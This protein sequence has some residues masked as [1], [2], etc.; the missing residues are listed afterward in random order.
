MAPICEVLFGPAPRASGDWGGQV[1]PLCLL[2]DALIRVSGSPGQVDRLSLPQLL[3]RL[4]AAE[5]L[6]FPML[7]PHQQPAWHAFLVQLAY[8]ALESTELAKPPTDAASWSSLLRALTPDHPADEPWCLVVDDWQR[9]AFLQSPCLAGGQADYRRVLGSA[10][11]IDLLITSKNHDEKVGK[12]PRLGSED[13]DLLVFALVSLQGFSGFLGAGNYNTLRMNGG[14]ASRAQFRLV[15]ARGTGPEFCRDLAALQAHTERMWQD[16][17]GLGIGT[18]HQQS[19]LWLA[20]WGDPA[21]P[22]AAVHPLCLEVCRRVRLRSVDGVLQA[23]TAASKSARVDAKDRKGVVLDPWLPLTKD[24]GV[25]AFTAQA[26]SFGYR[27][28]SP[29]LFDSQRYDLPLLARPGPGEGGAGVLLAQVLVGGSGRTDGLLRREIPL[30]GRAL[31]KFADARD[32][33][34]LRARLFIEIT[35]TLQGKVLRSALLQFIDGSVEPD[36]KNGDFAKYVVRWT[37]LF[38]SRVDEVFY[39]ALF[40]TIEAELSDQAA[41]VQWLSVLRPLAQQVF[42]SAT[43]ALPSRDGSRLIALARA[44]RLF[45]AGLYKQF[46]ALLP[47]RPA[48]TATASADTLADAALAQPEPHHVH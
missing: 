45:I 37:D 9:P 48:A 26:S 11:E 21:L 17:A 30:R 34:A 33:L 29:V 20:P 2:T 28:L 16:A 4:S 10:Q 7:R 12:M 3:A 39:A 18:V 27:L 19:L 36:W 31:R 42:D 15:F 14:F 24:G 41:Q 13:A 25:R 23:L 1:N 47:P 43:E 5:P 32:E 40:D 6:D 44:Q 38:D 46:G 22:L 35:S 8:L